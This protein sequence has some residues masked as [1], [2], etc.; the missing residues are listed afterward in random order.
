MRQA[1]VKSHDVD[2]SNDVGV[3]VWGGG[4]R[5]QS[6]LNRPQCEEESEEESVANALTTEWH[7][8]GVMT[9]D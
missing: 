1:K 9:G 4:G 5:C 2:M 3:C 6:K 8:K 7:S